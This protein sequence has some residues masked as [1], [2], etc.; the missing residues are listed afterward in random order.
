MRYSLQVPY[1]DEIQFMGVYGNS[2]FRVFKIGQDLATGTVS[3]TL[4]LPYCSDKLVFLGKILA[5]GAPHSNWKGGWLSSVERLY[6]HELNAY[7][8]GPAE[9]LESFSKEMEATSKKILKEEA[10]Q[11]AKEQEEQKAKE[12]KD[13]KL[14]EIKDEKDA[15]LTALISYFYNRN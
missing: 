6:M 3:I 12:E 2:A 11:K 14:K 15:E 13:R 4:E 1:Q 7:G 5:V 8:E 10:E 9:F